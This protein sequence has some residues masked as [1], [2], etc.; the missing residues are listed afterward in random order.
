MGEAVEVDVEVVEEDLLEEEAA[1]ASHLVG[2][3]GDVAS[4]PEEEE[5]VEVGLEDLASVEEEAAVEEEVAVEVE[6]S[7]K[8]SFHCF[9]NMQLIQSFISF[10]HKDTQMQCEL[11]ALNAAG[12]LPNMMGVLKVILILCLMSTSTALISLAVPRLPQN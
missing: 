11:E 7:K 10:R 1:V 12:D 9:Q 5:V 6:D 2:V 4:H 8:L 3:E